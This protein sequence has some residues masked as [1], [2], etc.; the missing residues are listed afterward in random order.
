LAA[1]LAD[2]V[3]RA[4]VGMVESRGRL[5]FPLETGEGLR[6]SSHLIGQELQGHEAMQSRVLGLIDHTHAAT[7]ELLHDAVVRDGLADQFD[8]TPSFGG[9]LRVAAQGKSTHRP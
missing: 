4:D 5:R 9:N 6:V 7:A 3:N 1:L 2:V 8:G